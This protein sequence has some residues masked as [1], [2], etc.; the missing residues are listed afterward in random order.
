VRTGPRPCGQD[1]CSRTLPVY[2]DANLHSRPK[3]VKRL[4]Y[5]CF[6]QHTDAIVPQSHGRSSG[7]RPRPHPRPS[8]LVHLHDNPGGFIP[9]LTSCMILSISLAFWCG[10]FLDET[11]IYD[12]LFIDKVSSRWYHWSDVKENKLFK[13]VLEKHIKKDGCFVSFKSLLVWIASS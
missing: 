11:N 6:F 8:V 10:S 1:L 4:I 13:E 2:R 3:F 12:Y 9:L 5:I 7:H